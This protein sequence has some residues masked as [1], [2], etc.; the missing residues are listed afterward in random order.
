MVIIRR[1]GFRVIGRK[2]LPFRF[3]LK[4]KKSGKTLGYHMTLKQALNR[5]RQVNY[6]K[7]AGR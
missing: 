7:R 6:F 4:S 1:K 3:I 5:E 2:K